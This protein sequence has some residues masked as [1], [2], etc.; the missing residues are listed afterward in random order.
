ML[1]AFQV[2][3]FYFQSQVLARLIAIAGI[4]GLLVSSAIKLALIWSDA[5]LV[6]FAWVVV[7]ENGL[8]GVV[9]CILYIKQRLPLGNWRFRIDQAMVLL[10]DSW[11]LILSG[12]V[13]MIY[14][15]I[16]QVMIK[17]M[18]DNKAVGNYA[19]AVRLSEAW[20][21]VPMAITQSV[22]PAILHAKN[23]SEKLYHA[24]LQRLYDLM[25]WLAVAVALP[26][27]FLSGWLIGLL[28]GKEYSQAGGVLAIHI[29]AGVFVF[30]GVASGKWLLSEN[31]Q[32]FSFFRTGLGAF[33]NV[34][35]NLAL[36]PVW[37]I[38]GAAVA[39]LLS[40]MIA[41]YIGYAFTKKTLTNFRMQ[42][43]S[44]FWPLRQ[45]KSAS[46]KVF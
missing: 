6:W 14:M 29:W 21:F 9:L 20:Y 1:Q 13:I 24:R 34:I 43:K 44:F 36:I 2:I 30:I 4:A 28:F 10:K 31:M 26:T 5:S 22:F 42:T 3:E 8:K 46:L 19:V 38:Y 32:I 11:P 35:L 17:I 12:L 16:D 39:T 45:L 41:S 15:R 18:L 7:I 37:G 40:Q 27:T 33:S 23:Q 25:V